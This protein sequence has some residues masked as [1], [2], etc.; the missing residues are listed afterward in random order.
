[1]LLQVIDR[2]YLKSAMHKKLVGLTWLWGWHH[3]MFYKNNCIESGIMQ[4]TSLKDLHTWWDSGTCTGSLVVKSYRK[5][6]GKEVILS[7]HI[8]AIGKV[9]PKSPH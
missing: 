8:C 6:I 4:P 5:C 2:S 3:V 7:Y 9:K 1:M